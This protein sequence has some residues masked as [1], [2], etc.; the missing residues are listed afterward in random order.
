MGNLRNALKQAASGGVIKEAQAL[1]IADQHDQLI[2]DISEILTR[3]R[4]NLGMMVGGEVDQI[5]AQIKGQRFNA[6]AYFHDKEPD[7]Q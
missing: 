6:A 5:Q 2:H 1:A 3:I 7:G 4:P